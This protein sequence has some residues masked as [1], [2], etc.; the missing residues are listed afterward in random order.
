M[1][2][3]L[4]G[5]ASVSVLQFHLEVGP[6]GDSLGCNRELQ[7]VSSRPRRPRLVR[8]RHC[9]SPRCQ[10]GRV[11]VQAANDANHETNDQRRRCHANW[12]YKADTRSEVQSLDLAKRPGHH[13]SSQIGR[14][15]L[16]TVLRLV[17]KFD[18]AG[19]LVTKMRELLFDLLSDSQI[20]W[21]APQSRIGK[22]ID[23]PHQNSDHGDRTEETHTEVV[24]PDQIVEQAQTECCRNHQNYRDAHAVHRN[25]TARQAVDGADLL[26]DR[27]KHNSFVQKQIIQTRGTTW[28]LLPYQNYPAKV[29][30]QSPHSKRLPIVQV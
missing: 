27:M 28:L 9:H 3:D 8:P 16:G 18:A 29:S 12:L 15:R 14:T 30:K 21:P 5:Q 25:E 4:F 23:T 26:L 2:L 1:D 10:N 11:H 19:K 24:K 20:R 6:H 22:T 13:R 7:R 17:Q